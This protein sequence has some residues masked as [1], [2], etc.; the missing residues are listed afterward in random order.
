MSL[1]GLARPKGLLEGDDR[2]LLKPKVTGLDIPL[3]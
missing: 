2:C 3:E 1:G